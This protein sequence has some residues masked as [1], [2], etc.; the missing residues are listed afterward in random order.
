MKSIL[1]FSNISVHAK[2]FIKPFIDS[3]EAELEQKNV[4]ISAV[5]LLFLII[6]TAFCFFL[7]FMCIGF[8]VSIGPQVNSYVL[9]FVFSGIVFLV[10]LAFIVIW[11][12]AV[13]LPFLQNRITRHVYEDETIEM[14]D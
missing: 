11:R 14:K 1:S 5:I 4:K 12:Q 10:T 2:E 13:I 8:V 7:F 6:I 3:C 9:L